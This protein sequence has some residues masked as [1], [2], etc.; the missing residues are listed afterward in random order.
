MWKPSS[1][2]SGDFWRETRH[3]RALKPFEWLDGEVW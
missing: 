1:S 2:G 3:R